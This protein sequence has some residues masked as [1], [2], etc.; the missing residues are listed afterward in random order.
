MTESRPPPT[1]RSPGGAARRPQAQ[2]KTRF[3]VSARQALTELNKHKKQT[4]AKIG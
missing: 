3:T 1:A 4:P 2:P